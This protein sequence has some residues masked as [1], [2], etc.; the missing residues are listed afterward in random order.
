MRDDAAARLE[1]ERNLRRAVER[2]EIEV[3][4]QPILDRRGEVVVRFEALC[5]WSYPS[6]GYVSPARFIPIAEETGLIIPLGDYV[7]ITAC[8]QAKLWNRRRGSLPIQVAVNISPVQFNRADF[9]GKVARILDETGLNP[10]LLELE[11][12][13][14]LSLG[15]VE[16][17]IRKMR[18]LRA[19]GISVAMDDFGAGYSSLNYL[20][21]L[22]I[23]TLKIDRAFVNDIGCDSTSKNFVGSVISLAHG[24]GLKVVGEGVETVK[25]FDTLNSLMCDELQGFLLGKPVHSELAMALVNVG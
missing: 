17:A 22:P 24:L 3:H 1:L 18:Q 10:N 12:T 14:S 9:V 6:L 13:E 15:D 20:R 19:L 21:R 5:R 23:D 25:Q 7:L 11:L 2:G 8:R 16:A 4:F